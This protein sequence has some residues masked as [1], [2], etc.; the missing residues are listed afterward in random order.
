[1]GEFMLALHIT[2]K[3]TPEEKLSWA[4]RMY[5]VDGSGS[6]QFSEMKRVVGA[7]FDLLATRGLW[8]RLRNCLGGWTRTQ[9]GMCRRRNSSQSARR[10]KTSSTSCRAGRDYPGITLHPYTINI[11]L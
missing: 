9:T 4:F 3:G 7:V 11:Y 6:I 10:T 1:M 5:D 2:S 8:G